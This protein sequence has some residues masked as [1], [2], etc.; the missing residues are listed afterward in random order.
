MKYKFVD[1]ITSDVMFEAY[2]KTFEE[3]LLNSAEALSS[4]ICKIDK[5]SADKKITVAL[6]GKDEKDLL[7]NW[8]QEIIAAVDIKEMFFSKFKITSLK[9]NKLTAELYGEEI[10]PEK[11]ETVVKAVTYHK[12]ELEKKDESYKAVVSVDI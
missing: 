10:T 9:G 2:G 7:F 11:G 3:L 12:F 4:I 6:E 8:L 1:K 5:V